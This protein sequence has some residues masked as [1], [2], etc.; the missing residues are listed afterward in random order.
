MMKVSWLDTKGNR[1]SAEI[2]PQAELYVNV[3]G[4]ELAA[5]LFLNF[6]GTV[7]YFANRPQEHAAL[8]QTIGSDACERISAELTRRSREPWARVPLANLF[9]ARFLRSQGN[10]TAQ[11][12]RKLRISDWSV[13]RYLQS[14]DKRAKVAA[15]EKGHTRADNDEARRTAANDRAPGRVIMRLPPKLIGGK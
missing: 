15:K 3:L 10:K 7:V 13:R 4:L 5:T 12:A 11:I 14:D 6:G 1:Q 9:L 8:S 2:E